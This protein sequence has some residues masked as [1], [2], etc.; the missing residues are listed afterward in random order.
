MAIFGNQHTLYQDPRIIPEL[1]ET[2]VVGREEPIPGTGPG[3]QLP[4]TG[5]GNNPPYQAPASFENSF[6]G[7][8]SPRPTQQPVRQATQYAPATHTPFQN[9]KSSKRWDEGGS[10]FDKKIQQV[11]SPQGSN[12]PED[13]LYFA[14]QKAG[15]E[16][17][18]AESIVKNLKKSGDVDSLGRRFMGM[19]IKEAGVSASPS[20]RPPT[21]NKTALDRWAQSTMDT[22]RVA[23][24][25][26]TKGYSSR[27]AYDIIRNPQRSDRVNKELVGIQ[28]RY[29]NELYKPLQSAFDSKNP[30]RIRAALHMAEQQGL[31]NP[32]Q[33]LQTEQM[34]RNLNRPADTSAQEKHMMSMIDK[35]LERVSDYLDVDPRFESIKKI[36]FFPSQMK[37]EDGTVLS[38][39]YYM[40]EQGKD[41]I[42]YN[43]VSDEADRKALI[44]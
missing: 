28:D 3:P 33:I 36:L 42:K 30:M 12:R 15:A 25:G 9:Q 20:D 5:P 10:R 40:P 27:D 44:T 31:G 17:Y 18:T 41:G 1:G 26:V 7:K 38:P 29:A 19:G 11:V 16:K 14:L 34:L 35:Q 13:L 37:L 43:P 23:R 6:Q 22:Y 2:V 39:G 32:N 24:Q 21:L 8:G 4:Y